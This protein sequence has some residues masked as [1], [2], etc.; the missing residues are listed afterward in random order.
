MPE[1]VQRDDVRVR[2]RGDRA[3]LP[4]EAGEGIGV[5]GEPLG[6]DFDGDLAAEARVARTVDLPH[7]A[8]A[9]D[10]D[11]LV[12]AEAS[13]W[14]ESHGKARWTLAQ[15][16]RPTLRP[17][18]RATLCDPGIS[19]SDAA[20]F[21]ATSLAGISGEIVRERA[22][23]LGRIAGTLESLLEELDRLHELA[24][25]ATAEE[26]GW[27]AREHAAVREMALRYRWYLVVQREANGLHCEGEVDRV[28]PVPPALRA[29]A[30]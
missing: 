16:L 20:L 12:G 9:E 4:L 7:A 24:G 18:A 17:T 1:V 11:D 3:R 2:E 23:V 14:G 15:R 25:A 13:A 26:L 19:M 29:P 22:A 10:G 27:L 8:H 28:Y 6:H 30:T 5:A 21:G